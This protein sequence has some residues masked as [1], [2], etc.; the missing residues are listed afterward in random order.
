[1]FI[2]KYFRENYLISLIYFNFVKQPPHPQYPHY[3]PPRLPQPLYEPPLL[4]QPLHEPP[5]H[6]TWY[7]TKNINKS[8][9]RRR[10]REEGE[11][12]KEKRRRKKKKGKKNTKTH[13]TPKC[14]KTEPPQLPYPLYEPPQHEPWYE[15]KT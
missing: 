4:S 12:K 8:T 7:E 11:E 3:K 1:L 13:Y 9:E 2:L 14:T 6:E 10:R 5:Q 15:T